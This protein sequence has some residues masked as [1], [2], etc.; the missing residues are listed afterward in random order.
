MHKDRCGR[1]LMADVEEGAVRTKKSGF[2]LIELLVVIAIIALLAAILFPVFARARERAR[3]TSCASNMKQIGLGIIQYV[4]DFDEC[5]PYADFNPV[6]GAS[7][8][9]PSNPVAGRYKWMDAIY[10]YVKS[11]QIFN[12]PSSP[13]RVQKYTYYQ[14]LSG[15]SQAYGSYAANEL[16]YTG[17]TPPAGYLPFETPFAGSFYTGTIRKLSSLAAV[18]ETV[19]C[20]DAAPTSDAPSYNSGDGLGFVFTCGD[21]ANP[22]CLPGGTQ[23][24]SSMDTNTNS[25]GILRTGGYSAQISLRHFDMAN[26][27]WADGHVKAMSAGQLLTQGSATYG[28]NHT[29]KYFTNAAD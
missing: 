12:C 17:Q 22:A 14:N 1:Y 16:Y 8:P 3:Q 4:Q 26:V 10:P 11:E 13:P 15:D 18:A 6:M 25:M 21:P 5:L 9:S 19:F 2:T 20:I 24:S 28:S 29:L 7:S 23:L 27:L